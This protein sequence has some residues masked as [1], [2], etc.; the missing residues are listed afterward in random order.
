MTDEEILEA[1]RSIPRFKELP[2]PAN[3]KA[4]AEA[5]EVNGYR[6]P[7][8]LRRIYLEVANGGFGP[9]EYGNGI[10]GVPGVKWPD[11]GYYGEWED[12]VDVYRAFSAPHPDIPPSWDVPPYLVWLFDWGC[13]I[14]SLVDCRDEKGQMWGWDPNNDIDRALFPQNMN[15]AEWIAKALEGLRPFPKREY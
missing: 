15:L 7:P 4:V 5:E 11:D 6:L 10:L 12:I 8:L 2:E 13:A 3:E 14:W 9:N 1:I